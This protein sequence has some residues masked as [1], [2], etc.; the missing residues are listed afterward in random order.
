MND[1]ARQYVPMETAKLKPRGLPD[2][3][4]RAEME[5]NS[6]EKVRIGFAEQRVGRFSVVTSLERF[7]EKIFPEISAAWEEINEEKNQVTHIGGVLASK[8]V[9]NYSCRVAYDLRRNKFKLTPGLVK[10]EN[11]NP[12]RLMAMVLDMLGVNSQIKKLP[13]YIIKKWQGDSETRKPKKTTSR[14]T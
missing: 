8:E 12:D 1:T 13:R 2:K 10:K 11:K 7:M 3:K 4:S 14:R 6:T 9:P 5:K